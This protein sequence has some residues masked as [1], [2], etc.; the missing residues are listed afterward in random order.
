MALV[1]YRLP[2]QNQM[3]EDTI[4]TQFRDQPVVYKYLRLWVEELHECFVTFQ[5]LAQDR[6][7]DSATGDALDIIGRIVGQ[8]RTIVGGD[9]YN[10]FGFRGHLQALGFGDKYVEGVGGMWWSL[11][12]PMGGDVTMT[13]EQYRVA[14]KARIMRNNS[15]GTSED[16]LAYIKFVFGV[17]GKFT[18]NEGGVARVGVGRKLTNFEKALIAAE[19]SFQKYPTYYSPKPLG[20]TLELFEFDSLGTLGFIGT[21]GAKG[22]IS[23]STP[24]PDGG[25]FATIKYFDEL[26][27]QA[28]Q[29]EADFSKDPNLPSYMSFTRSTTATYWAQDGTLKTAATNTPRMEYDPTTRQFLGLKLEEGRTNL[30]VQSSQL[31]ATPWSG[32]AT[33]AG[34]EVSVDGST[35]QGWSK[36]GS[37]ANRQQTFATLPTGAVSLSFYARNANRQGFASFALTGATGTPTHVA[38]MVN[39][40]T[41]EVVLTTNSVNAI[42]S[43]KTVSGGGLV[44]ITMTTTSDGARIYLY[45]GQT[46]VVDATVTFFSCVQLEVGAGVSSYIPTT[47]ATVSRAAEVPRS[48]TLSLPN[49]G[50]TVYADYTLLAPAGTYAMMFSDTPTTL[51]N[52]IGIRTQAV[53]TLVNSTEGARTTG[54]VTPGSGVQVRAA[55]CFSNSNPLN[56]MAINGVL[57]P[58]RVNTIPSVNLGARNILKLGAITSAVV[59]LFLIRNYAIYTVPFSEDQLNYL[60]ITQQ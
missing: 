19:F 2:D 60:T 20:V 6:D 58:E 30:V 4:T 12:A 28:P 50:W 7:I 15:R 41:G 17:N 23:L 57:S 53:G 39:T 43:A 48:S 54:I 21:P 9:L 51:G 34:T 13:D 25:I 44:S 14:I 52:Y 10:F 11:G 55:A 56:R 18:W 1:P 31:G 16:M 5:S 8:E 27:P 40:V 37:N 47:T 22:M 59:G 33:A 26:P 49:D 29:Y 32:S 46:T 42:A 45:P 24:N 3:I 35:V 38:G 36:T